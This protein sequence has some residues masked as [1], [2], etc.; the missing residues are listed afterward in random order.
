MIYKLTQESSLK[1]KRVMRRTIAINYS[2]G[3]LILGYTL[4]MGY[5]TFSIVLKAG[6]GI[7]F[8]V[9]FI[10][11]YFYFT[12]KND[13]KIDAITLTI[14]DYNI[15]ISGIEQQLPL[16]EIVKVEETKQ[17]IVLTSKYDFKK[18]LLFMK[19]SRTLTS[20]RQV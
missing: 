14:T 6:L 2:I 5:D 20:S 8:L 3:L 17:G 19:G 7:G 1:R 9:L 13:Q 11:A 18:N 15:S 16:N 10:G 12:K 4:I